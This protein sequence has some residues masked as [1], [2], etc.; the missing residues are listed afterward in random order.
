MASCKVRRYEDSDYETVRNIFKAG[1]KEHE[2][3]VFVYMLKRPTYLLVLV[4]AFCILLL[5]SKSLLLPILGVILLVVL[6]RHLVT[7]LFNYYTAKCFNSDFKDICHSYM[8]SPNSCFWVAE[9]DRCVVGIVGCY[10]S[11]EMEGCLEMVRMA[12]LTAYR[13]K[14][15]AKVLCRTVINFAC[16]HGYKAVILNTSDVQVPAQ[17]L[18]ENIGFKKYKAKNGTLPL[19]SCI[20]FMWNFT[21]YYYKYTIPTVI[22]NEGHA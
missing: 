17:K 2:P 16:Q 4:S 22:E 7:G 12:V 1:V 10:P 21:I 18:Y 6:L 20:N 13:G 19:L 15:I 11:K 3:A 9:S 14:G 8:E 5:S